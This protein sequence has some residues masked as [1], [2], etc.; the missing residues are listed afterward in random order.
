[1]KKAIGISE[2]GCEAL[3]WH[4]STPEPGDYTEEYQAEYHESLINQIADRPY[5]WATHV[6][7]MFD[8][9]ADA[10]D[11]GGSQGMNN[12]GL[13]TFD[14]TYKKDSF[15]AYKAWLSDEPFVHVAGKR[16][17]DRV[18]DVTKVTVYSNIGE[19][20]LFVN[21]ESFE[22]QTGERFFYFNVPNV[23]ETTITVKAGDC[24]DE[25]K[26]RKVE[27]FNQEYKMTETNDVINWFEIDE[28]AGFLSINSKI[29]E[30]AE[31]PEGMAFMGKMMME[32][33]PSMAEQIAGQDGGALGMM[34]NMT[35]K[36]IVSLVGGMNNVEIT[37]EL[38]LNLNAE[39]NKIKK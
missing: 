20:E 21:G 24:T 29:S 22:K 9:A 3:N 32:L 5:L 12:K 7:N 16:Y 25:S 1:M 31:S 8:F 4:T 14:R 37:K 35:V 36:R 33:V 26:I 18:E 28:P 17:V 2:Y 11:E 13:V 30:V 38:M 15:Y 34:G 10:R 6:W 19:V 39:L 23:G 27:E